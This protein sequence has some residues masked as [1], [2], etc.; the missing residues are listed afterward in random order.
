METNGVSILKGWSITFAFVLAAIA[1]VPGVSGQ[2]GTDATNEIQWLS[3]SAQ[4]ASQQGRYEDALRSYNQIA[5]LSAAEPKMS[6]RAYFNIGNTYMLIKKFDL[7]VSAF[8]RAVA[9]DATFAE[10]YNNLGESLG[11]LRQFPRALEAF[12]RA[13]TL[14]PGLSK[15]RY[16]MGVTYDRLGQLKYAEFIYRHL[17]RDK[18][19]Y[20]LAYDGLAVSLSKSGRAG[21]AIP[22]HEKA[23]S[24]NSRDG[25]YYY[26]LAISYLILGNQAKAREQEQRLRQIDPQIASRLASVLSKQ[27]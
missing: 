24:L 11:E 19:E 4:V 16:N 25:S 5:T 3:R 6:S 21:E 15:A 23:I 9:I 18:P 1:F 14:D 7:A 27:R 26:N 12:T 8:Q 10:A 22:F 2:Q 17:I 20:A 13:S